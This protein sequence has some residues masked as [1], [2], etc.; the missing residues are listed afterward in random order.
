MPGPAVVVGAPD[1]RAPPRG[2]RSARPCVCEAFQGPIKPAEPRCKAWSPRTRAAGP[3]RVYPAAAA[4]TP[5]PPLPPALQRGVRAQAVATG[6]SPE[7]LAFLERKRAGSTSPA[8]APVRR[9]RRASTVALLAW[10]QGLSSFAHA[11]S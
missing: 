8:P 10:P 11:C 9:A 5:P 6:L 1:P 4:L 7:Q 3:R 2:P